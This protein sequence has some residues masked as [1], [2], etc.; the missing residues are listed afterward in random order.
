MSFIGELI[1]KPDAGKYNVIDFGG[2]YCYVEGVSRITSIDDDKIE[3]T[4]PG[5][6]ILVS[7]EGLMI[8]ELDESTVII[9]G[10]IG[11]VNATE[12]AG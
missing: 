6:Q 7:G 4:V 5:A 3:L 11:G 12:T 8:E 10:R 2:K 9:K 1:N